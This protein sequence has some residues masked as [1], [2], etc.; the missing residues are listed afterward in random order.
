MMAAHVVVAEGATRR[1]QNHHLIHCKF[2]LQ[3]LCLSRP[4]AFFFLWPS[5]PALYIGQGSATQPH[6]SCSR[7]LAYYTLPISYFFIIDITGVHVFLPVQSVN[8][9]WSCTAV[10]GFHFP[11]NRWKITYYFSSLFLCHGIIFPFI[12][13][14]QY[15]VFLNFSNNINFCITYQNM[16]DIFFP[17]NFFNSLIKYK[18][19]TIIYDISHFYCN[20]LILP[21][22]KVSL[23]V[24]ST[25]W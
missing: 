13:F 2:L 18:L 17:G 16:E 4:E 21:F 15:F 10:H 22:I 14:T 19:Q 20:N 25:I 8:K 24:F 23:P 12:L 1:R 3:A 9:I 11:Q 6:P 5:E 7:A